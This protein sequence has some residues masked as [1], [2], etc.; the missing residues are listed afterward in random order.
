[1]RQLISLVSGEFVEA[2]GLAVVLRHATAAVPVEAPESGLRELISLICGEL[3][4]ESG[5][6]SLYEKVWPVD[7]GACEIIRLLI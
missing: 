4:V 5:T 3:E 2:C 6:L 7:H 1:L